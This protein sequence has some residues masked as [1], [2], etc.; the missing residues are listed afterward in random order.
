MFSI[1]ID[2]NIRVC[3]TGVKQWWRNGVKQTARFHYRVKCLE[4]LKNGQETG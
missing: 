3:I 1:K 2:R 4:F